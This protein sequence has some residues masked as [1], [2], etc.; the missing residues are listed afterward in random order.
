MNNPTQQDKEALARIMGWSECGIVWTW[1]RGNDFSWKIPDYFD[2][3]SLFKELLAWLDS[4]KWDWLLYSVYSDDKISHYEIE[5]NDWEFEKPQRQS[6]MA[7]GPDPQHA[8]A[9]AILE[10]G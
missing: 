8:V 3:P 5:L 6:R 9:W 1:D 4:N 10:A 2:N 7:V